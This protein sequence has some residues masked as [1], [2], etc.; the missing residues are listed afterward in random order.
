M[1]P[2]PASSLPALRQ[3]LAQRYPS[4]T[5]AAEATLPTGI[6]VLDDTCGG[7]PRPGLTELVCAAPSCGSQLF[8]GQLLHATRAQDLRVALV[9]RHDSFDPGS[10]PASLLTHLV[11]IR[12]RQSEEALTAADL[13]ARDANLALVILDL[14]HAPLPELRRIKSPAWYRLQRAIEPTLLAGLVL[15]P[16]PLVPSARLRLELARP[17]PLSVQNQPRPEITTALAPEFLRQRANAFATTG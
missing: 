14:H 12:A 11:W 13:L 9:D 3:L 2:G 17:H 8:L 6:P 7:L 16:F 10:W 15:T 5:R 1:H 4:A